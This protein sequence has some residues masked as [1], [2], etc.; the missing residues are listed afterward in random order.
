MRIALFIS[1]VCLAAMGSVLVYGFAAGDFWK[2]GGVLA[3]MPWGIVSLVDLYAGFTLFS[4]WIAYRERSFIRAA[5]WV[6]S[7]MVLGFFAGSL[8]AL[9]AVIRSGGDARRFW[10]GARYDG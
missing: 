1:S 9:I 10:L 4:C 6:A 7:M 5:P 2:E 8:Y 3:S